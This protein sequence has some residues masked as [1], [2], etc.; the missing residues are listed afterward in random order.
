MLPSSSWSL[1]V[2]VKHADLAKSR[3]K[4]PDHIHKPDLVRAM[5]MDVLLA[6][7]EVLPAHQIR[8]I[9]ADP[10]LAPFAAAEGIQVAHDPGTGL[11]QAV[12]AGLRAVS[13]PRAVLLA[14]LPTLTGPDLRE[15]LSEASLHASAIVPDTDGTGTVLLTSKDDAMRPSFGPGS[16]ARHALWAT[17]LALDLPR[18]RRDVD[19]R[20]DLEQARALG[21]GPQT[22]RA[23]P[24]LI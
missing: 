15:G 22:R 7:L 6:A 5:A 16:A 11:N 19:S 24:E 18:L 21:L 12:I 4:T 17:E 20:S 2:P 10:V 1:V 3:L 13:G 23:W 8:L 9:T 14:D